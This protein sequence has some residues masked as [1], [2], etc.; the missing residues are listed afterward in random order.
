M[1]R[2]STSRRVSTSLRQIKEDM[3]E[4][5]RLMSHKSV[6]AKQY[7]FERRRPKHIKRHYEGG[8]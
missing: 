5:Q 4:L 8:I 7:A 1:K 2:K 3:R 6:Y